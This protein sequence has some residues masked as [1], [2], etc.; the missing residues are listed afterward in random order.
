MRQ[1]VTE[2]LQISADI[3][4]PATL[5]LLPDVLLPVSGSLSYPPYKN[6]YCTLCSIDE[7]STH[8]NVAL[9]TEVELPKDLTE[10]E[11]SQ[12]I[13]FRHR[14]NGPIFIPFFNL[15][16]FE[17]DSSG[18]ALYNLFQLFV[19]KLGCAADDV[20]FIRALDHKS[21]DQHVGPITIAC[22]GRSATSV[23]PK[24]IWPCFGVGPFRPANP[25]SQA[26]VQMCLSAP[27]EDFE[28]YCVMSDIEYPR[29]RLDIAVV[30]L[31]TMLETEAYR[32]ARRIDPTQEP[33][34]FNPKKYF[35]DT[36][37]LKAGIPLFQSN[38]DCYK[39]CHEL[40]GTRHKIVHQGQ[41]KV[42]EF[43]GGHDVDKSKLRDLTGLEIRNF[44]CAAL[45]AIEWMKKLP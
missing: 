30:L 42:R 26:Q 43:N 44:R 36:N 1:G 9:E 14:N 20:R 38:Y 41:N 5:Q 39:G 4:I 27:L 32:T 28:Q 7:Q 18:W 23:V 13:D 12:L 15:I 31:V 6:V 29:G 19:W 10:E 34:N 21:M 11:L 2:E 37:H 17:L 45:E 8:F 35:G 25:L 33:P 24:N 40:W 16:C 22:R 3:S